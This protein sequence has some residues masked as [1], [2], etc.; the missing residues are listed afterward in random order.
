MTDYF[1][2]IDRII[3]V[4]YFLCL[5]IV[6]STVL[7]GVAFEP[8]A[9]VG[10]ALAVITFLGAWGLA[11]LGYNAAGWYRRFAD[12]WYNASDFDV[13]NPLP[14]DE[15]LEAMY[16]WSVY[17]LGETYKAKQSLNPVKRKVA[18]HEHERALR[19]AAAHASLLTP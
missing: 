18:R 12:T 17:R 3:E 13:L 19:I 1:R 8:Y 11:C 15:A 7:L 9:P 2:R 16:A 14:N 10:A 6:L 5:S 4:L